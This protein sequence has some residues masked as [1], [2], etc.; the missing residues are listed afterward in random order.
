MADTRIYVVTDYGTDAAPKAEHLVR[1][2]NPSQAERF[3]TSARFESQLAEQDDLV[4]LMGAGVKVQDA[5]ATPAGD[6]E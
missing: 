1:A 3:I 4:R 2:K 6:G 5:T